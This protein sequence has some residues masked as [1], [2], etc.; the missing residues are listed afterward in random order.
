MSAEPVRAVR[1][2]DIA[3]AISLANLLHLRLWGEVLAVTT[4]DAFY[5]STDNSD[6]W[7]LML[8]ILLLAG[9]FLGANAALRR[10]VANG[11]AW[12]VAGFVGVLLVQVN[13]F[14]PILA[15]GIF[16]VIDPWRDRKY[17]D[18]FAPVFGLLMITGLC[19]KWP[20]QVLRAVLGLVLFL[21]PMVLVMY[22]RGLL[23][24]ARVNPSVTL[25]STAPRIGAPLD[26]IAG[27]RVVVIVFDAM[28]RRLAIEARPSTLAMPE[29]DRFRAEGLEATHVRQAGVNTGISVPTLL[30]GLDVRA[31]KAVSRNELELT[32]SDS[33]RV[34][35]STQP[36]LFD[37]AKSL[38]G[39]A[40][41]A[42]WYFPYCRM[43]TALDGCSTHAARV[44]GAR[45]RTTSFAV[46]MRDQ[47]IALIPYV[48]LRRRQIAIVEAQRREMQ[49]AVVQGGRGLIWLHLVQPHTPWIWDAA[50]KRYT[51]TQFH[52]DGYFG[53]LA[54]AD[55]M[56]GEVRRA[57]EASGDW[58]ST[59]VLILSDHVTPYLPDY[60]K[61]V[62]DERVPFVLKLPGAQTGLT[63][64][65]PL[66]ASV[67]YPLVRALLRGE[68]PNNE[69][70][71]AWLT[72]QTAA[73]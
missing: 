45:G 38:G 56:L 36:T 68:I 37:D 21:S 62:S 35:W 42:G 6:I 27:P 54:L 51:L 20:S 40:L 34:P 39:V 4:P 44:I 53:N 57:M 72:R 70:A 12:V 16:T 24:V 31:A 14:G 23:A 67:T 55:E 22:G 59:A 25:A 17:I 49:H 61:D 5:S 46:T 8:N 65:R 50:A 63:Y 15:P 73:P 26:S 66:N 9:I 18:A 1:G 29:F 64:D 32:L 69:A 33:S 52:P 41:V 13:A 58:E 28:T 60:L 11:R 19:V 47:A 3:I 10:Y 7:A 2:K 30:S 71:A 48:N 43:F